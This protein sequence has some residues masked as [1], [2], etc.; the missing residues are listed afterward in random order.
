MANIVITTDNKQVDLQQFALKTEIPSLQG[1][2]TEEWVK[3]QHYLTFDD[4]PEDV[5]TEDWVLSQ[6]ESQQQQNAKPNGAVPTQ[7]W[8]TS[9]DLKN[10]YTRTEADDTFLKVSD[11][12]AITGGTTTGVTNQDMLDKLSGYITKEDANAQI[13]ELAETVDNMKDMH[14]KTVNGQSLSGTGN[15]T[16]S[17]S[18]DYPNLQNFYTK[19]EIDALCDGVK[20][21]RIVNRIGIHDIRY[22][23][24]SNVNESS[25]DHVFKY[26]LPYRFGSGYHIEAEIMR[27]STAYNTY[28]TLLMIN[29][30][31]HA[32][33][34]VF[35]YANG[36][37]YDWH[38]P[39]STTANTCTDTDNDSRSIKNVSEAEYPLN[40]PMTLKIYENYLEMANSDGGVIWTNGS[41]TDNFANQWYDGDYY[42]IA[43][44]K[45][46]EYIHSI[47]NYDGNGNL[48]Y[49][50]TFGL[51]DKKTPCFINDKTGEKYYNTNTSATSTVNYLR[52]ELIIGKTSYT[53][54]TNS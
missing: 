23:T 51:D 45:A 31:G 25:D 41:K 54:G 40:T 32:P 8:A 53:Y 47:K 6:I 42:M 12:N 3:N 44:S 16:I 38:N 50:Y 11:Y 20:K 46:D 26:R 10:Y 30:G 1:Y 19:S 27:S 13:Q 22:Y 49:S 5:A 39:Q 21:K 9:D 48:I 18:P 35:F 15:I 43:Y 29:E 33:I 2:A 52:K 28:S 7:A 14:L 24:T 34:E 37:Y 17:I 36:F 4:V